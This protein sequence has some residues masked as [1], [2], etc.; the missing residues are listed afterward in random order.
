MTRQQKQWLLA[1]MCAITAQAFSSTHNQ[2]QH[3]QRFTPLRVSPLSS[4]HSARR[5]SALVRKAAADNE[6]QPE[7]RN[8]LRGSL[9]STMAQRLATPAIANGAP[10]KQQS[11]S[12]ISV[13]TE[14]DPDRARRR[15]LLMS[16]LSVASISPSLQKALA[17]EPAVQSTST[18][19]ADVD[20]TSKP[21]DVV[22]SPLDDREY[23]TYTLENGLRV[24][25]CSDSSTN[26]AAVAMDVHV[27]ASSDPAQVPGLAHFCEHMLFLGTKQYPLENSFEAFLS[28]N[29]G[30]SNAFTD[31]ENTVY[32]FDMEA[33]ASS[34]FSEGLKRFGSFFSDPLFSESATGRELNAIESE[35]KVRLLCQKTTR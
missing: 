17:S 18:T 30:S 35:N 20:A 13:N 28:N 14:L 34:K 32:Y 33:E 25:L 5:S 8:P 31:S 4:I 6:N 19:V 9:E 22:K 12:T 2:L 10:Q 16:M 26:E 3:A 21:I 29:G 24:L 27:G 7:K 23:F 1:S 15:Q 11:P